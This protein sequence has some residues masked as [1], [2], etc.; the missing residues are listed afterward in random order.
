M[1]VNALLK[2][3]HG[4]FS[5]GM[6][7]DRHHHHGLQLSKIPRKMV[8]FKQLDELVRRRWGLFAEGFGGFG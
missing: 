5:T 1:T 7:A 4:Q 6:P 2:S 3:F 8:G